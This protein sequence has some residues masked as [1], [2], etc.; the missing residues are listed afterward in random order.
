MLIA[1]ALVLS[2]CAKP[3]PAPMAE[4]TVDAAAVRAGLDA[5]REQYRQADL[6]GD[7]AAI[8]ALYDVGGASDFFRAPPMRG[9][10]GIQAGLTAAFAALKH[11]VVEITATQTNARNNNEA[12]EIG[13]YHNSGMVGGKRTHEW[14]RWLSSAYKDSTGAWKL[15]YL[16][17]FADSNKTDK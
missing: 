5:L 12:T 1:G 10:E 14:G 4:A 16:M 7:A 15:Q 13:T 6:A 9:K 3:A 11:D 2:A 8:A 17:A